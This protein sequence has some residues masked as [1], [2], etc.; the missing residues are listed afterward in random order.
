MTP[1]VRS[2]EIIEERKEKS[3]DSPKES[4]GIDVN[5]NVILDLT[6]KPKHG[7]IR[8]GMDPRSIHKERINTHEAH[9]ELI[10]KKHLAEPT[11]LRKI[12]DLIDTIRELEKQKNC[13]QAES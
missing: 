10:F 4:E 13:A 7:E 9:T 6:V 3:T 8:I 11:R 2:K 1:A 12:N 5:N